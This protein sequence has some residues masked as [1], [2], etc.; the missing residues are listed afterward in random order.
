M[1]K[2]RIIHLEKANTLANFL[3]KDERE[4][5]VSLKITGYI[6][7]KD[8][9][10][11]LDEM[12]DAGGEYDDND[13][14]I[15]DFEI[16]PALRH[17]DLGDAT[18]VD[19]EGLP[20]FGFHAQLETFILPQ[21]LTTIAYEETGFCES[22]MLKTVVLPEGL[23]TVFGFNSCPN[24]SGLKL[25]NS[26]EKIESFAFAG[27]EAIS[28][29][30]IPAS[31]KEID[32]SC[33]ADCNISSFEI[34][35]NNPY[36]SVVDG[37]VFSK[38]LTTL[39]AFPSAYPNKHYVVPPTTKV[40]GFAAFMDS[41]IESL[42]LPE[43]L[44]NIGEWSFQGSHIRGIAMPDSV[45]S[46]GELAFRFCKNIEKVRLSNKLDSLP[47]QLFSCCPRLK[48][49]DIP[50]NVKAINYSA[51]AWCDGL[52]N[53]Y[54]HDGLE[55]IV[56]EGPMLGVKDKLRTVCFPATLKKVP[57]GVFNYTPYI[58]EFELNPVNPYFKIIDG[59]L[60]SKDGLTLYSV[61]NY[62]RTAYRVPEGIEVIAERVFAFLPKLHDIELPRTLKEI[63]SRAFQ[64]CESLN[65]L[66]IPAGV[67]QIDVD[68]LWADNLKTVIM[69][70]SV[71]PEMIG[72]VRDDEWRYRKTTLIVPADA[73][74]AYKN[75]PG[76]KCFNV[77]EIIE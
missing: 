77:K 61:P 26:V 24:L 58:K 72:N 14:F 43:G 39:V 19:G 33:F 1:E 29:L 42:D 11:V 4:T 31:V 49:L 17:L 12:C 52:E 9:D 25:P 50:S 18:Y 41:K 55:E 73:L 69:Q 68:A 71:P 23:K 54:L 40:I 27:C 70:G 32:G 28:S 37:V 59:A 34:D 6:G 30:R 10:D 36:Y 47:R 7:Q 15:P 46:V 66:V 3:S 60:C 65:Q 53:L 62:H 38:D 22:D 75:A 76:W 64:G 48:V 56:D 67:K 45:V 16:T 57:G 35:D 8:F 5:I 63:R 51:I 74:S 21:G 13:H 2:T 44:T 20:Y